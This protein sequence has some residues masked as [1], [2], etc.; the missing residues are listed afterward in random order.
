VEIRI[1]RRWVKLAGWA[2]LALAILFGSLLV[3]GLVGAAVTPYDAAG[4]PVL[5]RPELAATERYRDRVAGWDARLREVHADLYVLLISDARDLYRDSEAANDA[6]ARARSIAEAIEVAPAPPPAMAGLWELA[7]EAAG[8]H[9]D[10]ATRAALWV[11]SPTDESKDEAIAALEA[12]G[13]ILDELEANPWLV[14]S[15]TLTQ[16]EMPRR[17]TGETGQWG[18]N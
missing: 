9:L 15:D 2:A 10:A 5:L 7:R 12:A 4:N 16:Q 17:T 18:S 1:G 11:G 8:Q 13:V 14:G 3:A 6:A